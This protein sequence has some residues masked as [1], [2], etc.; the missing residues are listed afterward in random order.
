MKDDDLF[1]ERNYNEGEISTR[2]NREER[3]KRATPEVRQM[4][5]GNF[6]PPRGIIKSLT[7]SRGLRAVFFAIV[8][9]VVINVVVHFLKRDQNY[10]SVNGVKVELSTFVFDGVPLANLKLKAGPN[11][12]VND[13]SKE[14][15]DKEEPI[16]ELV[17]VQFSFFDKDKNKF[18]STI[19]TG[20][21]TGSDLSFATRDESKKATSVEVYILMK[22]KILKLTKRI[23]E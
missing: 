9:L 7:A 23:N 8:L 13:S 15:N 18:S 5:E 10:G 16:G 2:Y 22:E 3:L 21:Y 19:K 6:I 14:K 4:H 20:I 17:K 12:K 11:F 1:E